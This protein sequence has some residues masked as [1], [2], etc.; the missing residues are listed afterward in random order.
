MGIDICFGLDFLIGFIF[1]IGDLVLFFLSGL[2]VIVM[3]C[4]GVSGMVIVKMF[5]NIFIDVIVG[6]IFI[7]GDIFDFIYCVNWCNLYFL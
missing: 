1:G 7:F 2:L 5:W 6:I 4:K 3:V